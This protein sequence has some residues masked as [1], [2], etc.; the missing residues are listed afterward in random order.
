MVSIF[1]VLGSFL[2][3]ETFG[4]NISPGSGNPFKTAVSEA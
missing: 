2:I 3:R 4:R 1:S